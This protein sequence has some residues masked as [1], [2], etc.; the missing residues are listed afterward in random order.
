MR[1]F[2]VYAHPQPS[3]LNGALKV[4]AVSALTD[5]GHE[6]VVSDLYA[7]RCKAIADCN[8]F[9]L[10]DQCDRLVYHRESGAA[11]STATLAP[12]WQARSNALNGRIS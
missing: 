8:D 5:A 12:M 9:P 4:S 11:Y 2:I 10:H 7:I 3:S 1:Y 6:V